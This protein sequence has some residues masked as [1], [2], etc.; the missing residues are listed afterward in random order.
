MAFIIYLVK[1]PGPSILLLA[2]LLASPL[3]AALSKGGGYSANRAAVMIPF[4]MIS[5]AYGFF[6]LVRAAGRFRQWISLALL[7][8]AFVF[9]A[10]YLESYFF[11]SPFRIGTSMFAGMRELVDRSVSISREFPV[12]RVGRSIS[13]PH[14]FFAFYQA[15]DP[16]QYQQASRNWLVFEDKGLKFLDQYD[17]YSLGKFRFGDLKNSEPVSQPTLYI[18]R[19]EDFPSDYPYYFRLDS[20]NGQP[21]YQVSRR[22]P[23]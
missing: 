11:L 3:P 14:I 16:R 6:F 12:V 15:L 5:C 9:S 4:L 20:L 19:A 18:G 7:S 22:D 8:S 2:F 23:S 17:G 10:F 1:N 21:E 13:E